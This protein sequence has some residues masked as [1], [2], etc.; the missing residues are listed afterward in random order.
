MS[1]TPAEAATIANTATSGEQIDLQGLAYAYA[2]AA[3]AAQPWL[4]VMADIKSKILAA[5]PVGTHQAGNLTVQVKAGARSL[6]AKKVEAAYPLAENPLFY[7][8][9]LDLNAVKDLVAPIVLEQYMRQNSPS[10]VIK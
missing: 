4:D 2:E 1:I 9:T 3:E 6:D 5:V 8:Q 7:K 10:L